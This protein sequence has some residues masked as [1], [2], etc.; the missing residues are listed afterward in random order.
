[1]TTVTGGTIPT[2]DE[3]T[4]YLGEAVTL[5]AVGTG[6]TIETVFDL[7][8]QSMD[9]KETVYLD[10]VLQVRDT[11]YTVSYTG[12]TGGV[13]Q[14]TF[15]AAP[16]A[17]PITA[18]YTKAVEF[19]ASSGVSIDFSHDTLERTVHGS[20]TKLTKA[21]AGAATAALTDVL[22][23]A[24]LLR[25]FVGSVTTDSPATGKT[26]FSWAGSG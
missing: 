13:T 10:A 19:A 3:V 16:P 24:D 14:I 15:A 17:D 1:M 20:T 18:T 8:Y 23:D 12:G 4:W 21:G 26:I 5:E 9:Y 22:V 25:R 2:G 11:D 6:D 7:A